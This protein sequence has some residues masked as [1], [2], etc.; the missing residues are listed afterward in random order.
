VLN[1]C[2][3]RASFEKKNGDC[4]NGK[5]SVL[6]ILAT[7]ITQ[8]PFLDLYWLVMGWQQNIICSYF[9]FQTMIDILGGVTS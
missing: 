5:F 7:L 9:A 4:V 2:A 3:I 6:F 1:G 8:L